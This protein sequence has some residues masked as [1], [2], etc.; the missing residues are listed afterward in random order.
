MPAPK[1]L[2]GYQ[3][4]TSMGGD[5]TIEAIYV[6]FANGKVAETRELDE[7]VLLA[8]YDA[9]GVLLGI[10]ILAPVKISRLARLVDQDKRRPFRKA[11]RNAAPPDFVLA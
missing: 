4:S 3:V 9:N 5:G 7:D 11:M 1:Q 2:I 8:D 6:R 10:E